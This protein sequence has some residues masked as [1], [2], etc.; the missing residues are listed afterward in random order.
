MF[1]LKEIH[2]GN[3]GIT[4]I[5]NLI[6]N[7]KKVRTLYKLILYSSAIPSESR[8]YT[9]LLDFLILF[10]VR[11]S[12]NLIVYHRKLKLKLNLFLELHQSFKAPFI[13]IF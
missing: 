11:T 5:T 8:W 2:G 4:E 7:T 3:S 12:K 10:N 6:S 9:R 1:W 13:A